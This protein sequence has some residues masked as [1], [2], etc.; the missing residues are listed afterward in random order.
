MDKMAS[1]QSEMIYEF[2]NELRDY[3]EKV[4]QLKSQNSELVKEKEDA[5]STL[6]SINQEK[7]KENL[8]VTS[9][10]I[11]PLR[12]SLEKPFHNL[13]RRNLNMIR[14]SSRNRS[15]SKYSKDELFSNNSIL[16]T[17][18]KQ[19]RDKVEEVIV[20]LITTF[21]FSFMCFGPL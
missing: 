7:G 16:V 15:N 20:S 2:N 21:E 8:G 12:D 13:G 19:L 3:K 1:E 14:A 18:N 17:R 9:V 10:S 4:N 5:L 11:A 6:S